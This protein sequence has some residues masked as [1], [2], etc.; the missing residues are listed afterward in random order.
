MRPSASVIT[1]LTRYAPE[2]V[3]YT[4]GFATLVLESASGYALS[5][6]DLI[7]YLVTGRP[8][9]EVG[10][11]TDRGAETA[12]SV[13]VPTIG[14]IASETLR[15]QLGGWVDQ[16]RLETGTADSDLRTAREQLSGLWETVLTSR[17][18]GEKQIGDNWFVALSSGL[19]QLDRDRTGSGDPELATF[20]NQLEWS[21]EYRFPESLTIQAA[22]EPSRSAY[23]CN[24]SGVRGVVNTPAQWAISLSRTW[25]F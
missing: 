6:S 16:I 13:L 11:F 23:D 21:L 9:V 10:S 5:Q 4:S 8:S 19:C 1:T 15:E 12:T 25:R 17:V 24:R 20:V 14:T 7:S 18:S 2:A 3:K 22:R